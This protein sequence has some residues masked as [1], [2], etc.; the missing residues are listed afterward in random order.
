V[1]SKSDLER[2]LDFLIL[3]ETDMPVPV[4]QY[5]FAPP[6]RWKFDF[7][8]VDKKIGIECNGGIYIKGK[9]TF[10][11]QLEKDYEKLNQ[12]AIEG[13][14]VLQFSLGQIESGEAV[15]KIKEAL[16]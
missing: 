16:K 7:A 11:A 3:A 13:W 5:R 12:A 15:Q 10:G 2:L 9:H 6:R 1:T 4:K 14:K 8:Y